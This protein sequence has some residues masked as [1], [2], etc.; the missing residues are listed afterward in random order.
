MSVAVRTLT[1]VALLALV[2][3]AV[4]GC[5]EPAPSCEQRGGRMV[6]DGSSLMLVGKVMVPTMRYRCEGATPQ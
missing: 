5:D 6:R 1:V 3:L 2:V 4:T